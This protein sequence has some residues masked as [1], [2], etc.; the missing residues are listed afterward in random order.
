MIRDFLAGASSY[1]KAW[2]LITRHKLWFYLFVPGII[3]L[4]LGGFIAYGAYTS[5]D[6]LTQS[7]VGFYPE[8]WWGFKYVAKVAFVFSALILLIGGFLSYRLVL[9]ALVSPFMSPLAAKIQE[10]ETGLR[11][12]DPS[13]FSFT[14]LK[15]IFR[16]FFLSLRNLGKEL[17]YTVLLLMLGLIPVFSLFVPFLIFGIQAFYSGFGSLDYTLE[18]YY[19]ISD[20]KK[21]VAQNR[22]LAI[23]NGTVFLLLL[24]VPVLGL[25]LAPALSTAA[26]TL[27]A[28]KRIDAL[29][30]DLQKLQAKES[31]I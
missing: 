6:F 23:G 1:F 28:I 11:V 9:M 22:A 31:F 17:W 12:D 14:N 4:C 7:L 5:S 21:F 3:S 27:E 10:I 15:L 20:S 13:F 2:T 16:G 18:K 24:T 25:F 8:K 29:P 30:R 19:N 26:G